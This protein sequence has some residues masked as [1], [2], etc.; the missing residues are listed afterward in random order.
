[1]LPQWVE[2]DKYYQENLEKS[3]QKVLVSLKDACSQVKSSRVQSQE[4]QFFRKW[5]HMLHKH[6]VHHH[7]AVHCNNWLAQWSRKMCNVLRKI[8]LSHIIELLKTFFI[9]IDG[10]LLPENILSHWLSPN[11]K[12]C[13]VLVS[14]LPLSFNDMHTV[15]DG[16]LMFHLNFRRWNIFFTASKKFQK[17][18]ILGE[19]NSVQ[20]CIKPK[21]KAS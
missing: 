20:H 18:G 2:V 15:I 6:W 4:F 14:F 1:M 10:S 12:H 16:I 3:H 11:D 21:V 19:K 17:R 5:K 7:C 9:F 13:L 8:F